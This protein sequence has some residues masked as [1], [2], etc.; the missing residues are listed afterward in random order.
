MS[1]ADFSSIAGFILI[2][3]LVPAVPLFVIMATHRFLTS[4]WRFE[5]KPF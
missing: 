5:Y 1:I 3:G 4:G 2:V